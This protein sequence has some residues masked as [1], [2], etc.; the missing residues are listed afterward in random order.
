LDGI[1]KRFFPEPIHGKRNEKE[2]GDHPE[3]NKNNDVMLVIEFSNPLSSGVEK[4]IFSGC[5]ERSFPS[6]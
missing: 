2:D 1:P 6:F 4:I 3:K 5:F